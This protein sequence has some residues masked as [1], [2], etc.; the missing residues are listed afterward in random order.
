MATG[1]RLPE[2][3]VRTL[4]QRVAIQLG[5]AALGGALAALGGLLVSSW[6]LGAAPVWRRPSL[7]PLV[8]LLLT[9]AVLSIWL[10]RVASRALR[11]DR[12]SAASEI[13]ERVGLPAGTVQGA[14]EPGLERP[15]ISQ[16]LLRLHRRRVAGRL[17]GKRI[18]ELGGSVARAARIYTVVTL[19]LAAAALIATTAIWVNAR[20]S[21]AD[22]WVAVLHPVRHL[23]RPPLP[24]LQL[25]GGAEQVQ[26]GRDFPVTVSAPQRD[27]V[28]LIWQ[29]TGEVPSRRWYAVSGGTTTAVV[30]RVEA[31]TLVWARAS[32]GALSDTLRV[33]P[34]DPLLLLDVQL[35]LR[36]PAHT[37]REREVLS[38]PVPAVSV[39]DGTRAT[40]AGAT[41]RAVERVA[42][43][44][45]SGRTIAFEIMEERRFRSSFAVR[46]G[47][48]G[49]HIVGSGG[50]GLEGDPDSLFFSIVADSI[51]MVAIVY[52]GVDT[53]L[54]TAMVQP[55]VVEV[56]D[57]YGLSSVELVSWRI[58]AWGERWPDQVE[59]IELVD[60]GPRAN[61]PVLLDARGRG[62]LPGDTLRYFV[63]AYDNAPDPQMGKSREYVLRLPALEEL[64]E[65]AVADARGLVEDVERLAERARERQEST[66]A[67]E[68]ST[69]TR[70]A[71]D[72][73]PRASQSQQGV[74]FRDTEAAR[75]ALDEVSRL[76][77]EAERVQESL[78]EL[79][80]SIEQAG[81][82]DTS[83]LERLREIE[84]LYERILTPEL[85]EMIEKLRAALVE[86]D[87]EQIREAIER[88]AEGSVD[89]RERVE[90]SLE[91]LRRAALE[92]EFQTLETQAEEL[93]QAQD[94]LA[95]AMSEIGPDAADS[96]RARLERSAEELGDRADE[97]SDRVAQFAEQL[98]QAGEHNAA[99]RAMDAQ[100]SAGEAARSDEQAARALASS[101][102]Q[103][104]ESA[105][106]AAS[107]MRQAASALREGRQ[108]MQESWRQEVV[109][110]L[111]RAQAEALELARRQQDLNKRLESND[112]RERS[113]VRS[114][115]VAIK[116]GADQLREQLARAS[117]S[118][119]LLDQT[120]IEASGDVGES[121]EQLLGQ[122]GDGTRSGRGDP[123][124][125]RQV[126]ESL[127]E[128]AFQLMQAADA[129]SVA[130]SGTGLQDALQQLAQL[131]EQQG[132]LNAQA[133]GI[134]PGGISNLILQQL[135]QLASRQRA[136]AEELVNL[137]KSVGPRGQVLGHLES[138]AQE[139]EELARQLERG[140]LNQEIIERQSRLFQ[141]LLDAGR[142]LEQDEFERERR[143]ERPGDVEIL[144]PGELPPE[145]LRGTQYPLPADEVLRRYPPAYRR[146][147]LEYFDRLNGRGGTG[148]S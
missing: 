28:E 144:R 36:Y 73:D 97:L 101:G 44:S 120:V 145:L 103:A 12:R 26:R 20:E 34:V 27:S 4:W 121:L 86:L 23:T 2:E 59:V 48:W 147:I 107:Q 74:E 25:T 19:T 99:D 3:R 79:Q 123:K 41:T 1:E 8:F 141:R 76:L 87:P 134:T 130:Q 96:L 64:R 56:G 45:S 125:G 122:L 93:S 142:T 91:L 68:R 43:Q 71:S 105:R 124:L 78:R 72:A 92:A 127:N 110:A 70:Q 53:L 11:W 89:F 32:D 16:S 30:P 6:A 84:S 63:R 66:R 106:Q 100:R 69:G 52:P 88:L 138:L 37:R 39:P 136:I 35:T 133:G 94:E 109:Q 61:L 104:G 132:D 119:L 67:L 29:P 140:R 114:E 77:E 7:L 13:E 131:A 143:A 58:S 81:L 5:I 10:W 115:E 15:G 148:G 22:A 38:A 108:Q 126:S 49:W 80:E 139:A 90:Q 116:R 14:V 21:A 75:Q 47:A 17:A 65:R 129:A 135:R 85:E 113:E 111:E 83:V 24:P 40:V 82:N 42:L 50:A 117:K 54:S 51:P 95:D 46:P 60:D 102:W 55:L 146:L 118:T 137:N 33:T 98:S 31:P 18:A 57:D 9:A 128:L 62:F 112:P